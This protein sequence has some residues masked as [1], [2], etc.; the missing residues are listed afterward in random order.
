MSSLLSSFPC[1]LPRPASSAVNCGESARSVIGDHLL[2]SVPET[3]VYLDGGHALMEVGVFGFQRVDAVVFAFDFGFVL[4]IKFVTVCA[5]IP[6]F[7]LRSYDN[8]NI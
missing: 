7:P 1:S 2:A 3:D 5:E 4:Y 6:T 8:T